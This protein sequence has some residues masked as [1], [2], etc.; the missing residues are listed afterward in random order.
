MFNTHKQSRP[1]TKKSKKLSDFTTHF[2]FVIDT[3][4]QSRYGDGLAFFLAPVGFQIPPNSG[5]KYLGLFNSSNYNSPQNQIIV[6][7]CDT[8]NNSWSI[9]PPY[10]H[11]GINVNSIISSNFAFWNASLH[12]GEPAD[13]WVA[14]NATTHML[15]LSLRY[16]AENAPTD[17]IHL[18]YK[19][20]LREVLPELV[21]IG[22]SGAIGLVKE[23]H[24]LRYWKFSS[25]LKTLQEGEDESKKRKLVARLA[26]P[27]ICEY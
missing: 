23:K 18:S 22:F 3:L 7:E 9:E 16:G 25:S 1:G 20:D 17:Y 8:Y 13:A 11:V 19:V 2:T 4:N 27:L 5:G 6:V 21:A 12:S 10:R 24:T 15:S 26:I 14:F